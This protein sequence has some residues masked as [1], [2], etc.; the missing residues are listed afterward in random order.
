MTKIY[1]RSTIISD[2]LCFANNLS[3]TRIISEYKRRDLGLLFP[4]HL[5]S[6][7]N[8]NPRLSAAD[9]QGDDEL[10]KDPHC[11]PCSAPGVQK[12]G[13]KA[14]LCSQKKRVK[15]ERRKKTKQNNNHAFH[16]ATQNT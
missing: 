6:L 1:A 15:K 13:A 12:E 7:S 3:V 14:K 2:M 9:I 11:C 8:I 4:K 10:K 5:F 16:K